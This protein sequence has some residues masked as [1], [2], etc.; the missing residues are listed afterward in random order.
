VFG[1]DQMVPGMLYAVFE[2]SGVFGGKVKTHNLDMIKTLPGIK[3]AFVV[4]RP[5]IT[6]AVLP[7]DPG[8][9]SGIAIVRA[10]H[11]TLAGATDAEISALSP[12]DARLVLAREHG[13]PSWAAFRRHV[14]SL[15]ESGE[16]FRRAF[17]A[18][19]ARDATALG[20]LLDRYP[21][22][23][24]ARGTNGNDLLGL[25][26]YAVCGRGDQAI[27][28]D[29]LARGADPNSAND[30]GWT[31]LH[32]AGYG[33]DLR[34]AGLLL[35]AGARC[36]SRARRGRHATRRCPVLGTRRGRRLPGRARSRA[37]QPAHRRR[38]RRRERSAAS[39]GRMAA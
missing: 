8:L 7:G 4:D 34:L 10:H 22:L 30:R 39:C 32:Q 29:L 11:P 3:A 27:V 20:A 23:V 15:A 36:D 37:A 9:E 19:Q 2:K 28:R 24:T 5:D 14:D 25:A 33:N 35:A 31:P 38:A 17:R 16:P 12:A 26:A 1:I 6:A 18:I 21:G 13:F